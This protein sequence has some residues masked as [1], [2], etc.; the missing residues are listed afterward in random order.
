M[1]IYEYLCPSCDTKF[2]ML[3]PVS[4]CHE[5][6]SCPKCQGSA[7]R[8]LSRFAAFSAGEDGLPSPVGG[9]PCSSCTATSCDTCSM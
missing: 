3:R 8:V 2:E 4:E 6:A 1:P 5:P 7:Q 9:D